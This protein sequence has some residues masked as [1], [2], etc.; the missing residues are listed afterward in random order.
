MVVVNGRILMHQPFLTGYRVHLGLN[1]IPN[2]GYPKSWQQPILQSG[3][4][5]AGILLTVISEVIFQQSLHNHRCNAADVVVGV[6]KPAFHHNLGQ[7]DVQHAFQ[8]G[9]IAVK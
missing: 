2:T 7:I 9:Y 1:F 6:V 5:R 3:L 8:R 4:K